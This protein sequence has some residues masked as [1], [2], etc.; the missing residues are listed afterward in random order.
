MAAKEALF[1]LLENQ[2]SPIEELIQTALA[3]A[4]L[5]KLSIKTLSK[6]ISESYE[7]THDQIDLGTSVES[8][9]RA[10]AILSRETERDETTDDTG[11]LSDTSDCS[12][13]GQCD[14][15]Q[16]ERKCFNDV[17][18]SAKARA[19]AIAAIAGQD[20]EEEIDDDGTTVST[21][22]LT[23]V[24]RVLTQIQQE[25]RESREREAT[26]NDKI[27][28][29]NEDLKKLS[30]L[31][32]A[33]AEIMK[34]EKI[35][36]L[37]RE[38]RLTK[39]LQNLEGMISKLSDSITE[40]ATN[41]SEN[42]HKI[43]RKLSDLKALSTPR[44]PKANSHADRDRPRPLASSSGETPEKSSSP[45][46]N[47]LPRSPPSAGCTPSVPEVVADKPAVCEER[48]D[49][50][51]WFNPRGRKRPLKR[52]AESQ[53]ETSSS[54]PQ[55]PSPEGTSSC[56][57]R[58]STHVPRSVFFLRG[59]APECSPTD[60]EKYCNE[61]KIRVSSCR[62]VRSNS[63]GTH[64]ARLS[65]SR[66]DAEKAGILEKSFWPDHIYIRPWS[67]GEAET[68]KPDPLRN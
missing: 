54:A 28:E 22:N 4:R 14:D 35:A 19:L 9:V 53:T 60:I 27:K 57:L 61:K 41:N 40:A 46:D 8:H 12:S 7:D 47:D 48:E 67:F 11:T 51:P 42:H 49:D 21:H 15:S 63:F 65:V 24:Q 18:A 23:V 2:H 59:I 26:L 5:H 29:L 37:D 56:Q 50:N 62:F 1:A 38:T 52:L 13:N 55:A 34:E 66:E 32:V 36:A 39:R 25:R 64:A 45:L 16:R 31:V 58:G 30:T 33:Q 10:L 6:W 43:A 44:Q 68:L 3:C 17:E 20:K